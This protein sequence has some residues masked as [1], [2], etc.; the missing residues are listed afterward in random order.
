M[1]TLS[2]GTV[3]HL[4]GEVEGASVLA[5]AFRQDVEA[6]LDPEIDF[7]IGTRPIPAPG[8]VLDLG[9]AGLVDVWVTERARRA[10]VRI[11]ARPDELP[12]LPDDGY[13]DDGDDPPEGDRIV[14]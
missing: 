2:D 9:H 6:V 10:A 13:R 5:K 11:T 3:V 4:G 14:Y 1:W 7:R 8:H 12:E